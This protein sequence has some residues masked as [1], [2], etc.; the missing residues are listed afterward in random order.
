MRTPETLGHV[1][2]TCLWGRFGEAPSAW[3]TLSPRFVF[4][5]CARPGAKTCV[6]RDRCRTCL[7]WRATSS[8]AS[9]EEESLATSA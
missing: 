1:P 2:W 6:T 4:W 3:P 8:V 9:M 7:H 5:T